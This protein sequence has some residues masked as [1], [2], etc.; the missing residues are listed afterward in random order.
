MHYTV[1]IYNAPINEWMYCIS[2]KRNAR[3]YIWKAGCPACRDNDRALWD[4]A[5]A[6]CSHRST[7]VDR[8]VVLCRVINESYDLRIRNLLLRCT[9]ICR[10]I[11]RQKI[12]GNRR[13]AKKKPG[14]MSL[15]HVKSKCCSPL[16]PGLSFIHVFIPNVCCSPAFFVSIQSFEDSLRIYTYIS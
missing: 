14:R 16:R 11:L 12:E 13:K 1:R 4:C 7:C 5:R 6:T 8:A 15:C 9:C 3:D 10:V 2:W